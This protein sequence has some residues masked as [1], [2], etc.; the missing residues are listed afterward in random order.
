MFLETTIGER[1]SDITCRNISQH[2]MFSR[3]F[4]KR[5]EKCLSYHHLSTG[6]IYTY[7]NFVGKKIQLYG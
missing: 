4:E 1:V 5:Y 3:M 7:F 6:A 2:M